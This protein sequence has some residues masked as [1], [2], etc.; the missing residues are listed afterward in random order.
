[1]LIEF[2]CLASY[3]IN[4]NQHNAWKEFFLEWEQENRLNPLISH[5]EEIFVTFYIVALC[6][7]HTP[8]LITFQW[9]PKLPLKT[10]PI[11]PLKNANIF[12]GTRHPIEPL[13]HFLDSL[14]RCAPNPSQ[15]SRIMKSTAALY[16]KSLLT[17]SRKQ[18]KHAF[19]KSTQTKLQ[20]GAA[21][22]CHTRKPATF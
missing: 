8:I 18:L 4:N 16:T 6:C 11:H 9:K 22:K 20:S 1:M 2:K 17:T 19:R 3:Y 21:G 13:H 15:N 5:Q 7:C 14:R 10:M 12:A